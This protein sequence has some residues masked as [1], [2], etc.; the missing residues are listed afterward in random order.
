MSEKVCVITGGFGFLGSHVAAMAAA[1]GYE[2]AILDLS[3]DAPEG[4]SE[5]VG[6]SALLKG[7][8]DLTDL[9]SVTQALTEIHAHFGR[10]DA[11]FNIAG[12]FRWETL[13]DG[14]TDT[15][16]LLQ[17][18][19]LQ[20]ALNCSKA[21]LPFMKGAGKGRIV[22]IGAAAAL[23]A[24]M[25]MG[26]YTASKA[27]VHKLTES[28]AEELKGDNITVNA[29]LPSIIDTPTNRADMPDADFSAWVSADDLAATI[30]FLA[31]DEAGAIT[32]ALLPVTGRV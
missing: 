4:L 3:T 22:N 5:K 8:V 26:S 16:S 31:S 6:A 27:G 1:R 17:R 25:G 30:L 28:L 11:L 15:W 13:E 23:K 29:V 14:S 10:I 21:V 9:N 32:G 24:G 7:G 19:N 2:V 18:M 20:T 12:G